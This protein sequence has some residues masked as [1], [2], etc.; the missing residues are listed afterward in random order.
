MKKIL[1]YCIKH[2]IEFSYY[3][4]LEL[5][6]FSPGGKDQEREIFITCDHMK[7][8]PEDIVVFFEDWMV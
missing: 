5:W 2:G 1:K 3:P 8:H 4:D 7:K 6:R